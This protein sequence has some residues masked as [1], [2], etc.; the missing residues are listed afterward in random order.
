MPKATRFQPLIWKVRIGKVTP[1][2][3]HCQPSISW[4]HEKVKSMVEAP[5]RLIGKVKKRRA[6][7]GFHGN[8]KVPPGFLW[9]IWKVKT[10]PGSPSPGPKTM[11]KGKVWKVKR[12]H[13]PRNA[14]S[15][16]AYL[17]ASML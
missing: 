7:P 12:H 13:A 1:R 4:A 2:R 9:K 15:M 3:N 5:P 16:Q 14:S 17:T 6:I 11:R 8:G 10:P